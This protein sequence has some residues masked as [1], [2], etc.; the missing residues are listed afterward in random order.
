[1]MNTNQ[2]LKLKNDDLNSDSD[3][4]SDSEDDYI[5]PLDKIDIIETKKEKN[6]MEF[7]I[8]HVPVT[9]YEYDEYVRSRYQKYNYFK[10]NDSLIHLDITP[11]EIKKN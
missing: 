1:M 9:H 4:D 8:N 10:K 2:Y 11:K 5:S 6:D 3:S 7:F